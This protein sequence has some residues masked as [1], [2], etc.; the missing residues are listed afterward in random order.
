MGIPWPDHGLSQSE[1]TLPKPGLQ[2]FLAPVRN[3][4]QNLPNSER[5]KGKWQKKDL[6]IN[7]GRG[8]GTLQCF[9]CHEAYTTYPPLITHLKK[10]VGDKYRC[11]GGCTRR[12]KD[13]KKSEL[14][15]SM[16]HT[17]DVDLQ[18]EQVISRESL[19]AA[20]HAGVCCSFCDTF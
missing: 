6:W 12:K 2:C 5:S 16:Q 18:R 20:C 1:N 7:V 4:C 3:Q 9:Y 8:K 13:G 14:T 11:C 19:A 17:C 15:R 10:H